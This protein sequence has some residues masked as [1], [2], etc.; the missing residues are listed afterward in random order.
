MAYLFAVVLHSFGVTNPDGSAIL[1][2]SS[3]AEASW[4]GP[5]QLPAVQV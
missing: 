3:V 2:F 1:S 4:G 5:A